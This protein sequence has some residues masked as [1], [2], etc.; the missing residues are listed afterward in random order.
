MTASNITSASAASAASAAVNGIINTDDWRRQA[1]KALKS[2][3]LGDHYGHKFALTALNCAVC[4]GN[5]EPIAYLCRIAARQS[6][7]R[8]RTVVS[9][10]AR[11]TL[12]I[13]DAVLFGYQEVGKKNLTVAFDALTVASD[14]TTVDDIRTAAKREGFDARKKAIRDMWQGKLGYRRLGKPASDAE[15]IDR[16]VRTLAAL[17]AN[18]KISAEAAATQLADEVARRLEKL[19]K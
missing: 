2:W 5:T 7:S 6:K 4:N 17:I 15:K 11:A 8:R 3:A 16:A 9:T 18:G 1:A 19:G 13:I 10:C 12:S 14:A